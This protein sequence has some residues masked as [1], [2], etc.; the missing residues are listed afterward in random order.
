M[1]R[2][3]T[4]IRSAFAARLRE[5]GLRDHRLATL[6]RWVARLPDDR[7]A[8]AV[9]MITVGLDAPRRGRWAVL[10][11]IDNAFRRPSP[12]FPHESR[13]AFL[14]WVVKGRET[15]AKVAAKLEELKAA[16]SAKERDAILDSLDGEEA[17][18]GSLAN[19]HPILAHAWRA[20]PR[21]ARPN[22]GVHQGEPEPFIGARGAVRAAVFVA[23]R[24]A[25]LVPRGEKKTFAELVALAEQAADAGKPPP[26]LRAIV[27]R[28]SREGLVGIARAACAEAMRTLLHPDNAG[29]SARPAAVKA[30]N[31][32]L[33]SGGD[34][35]VRSFLAGLDAELRRLDVVHALTLRKK[36]PSRPI[37][38]TIHRGADKKGKPALWLARLEG[39]QLGLLAKQGRFW[40]WT[41]GGKEEILATVPDEHFENAVMAAK[42]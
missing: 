17:P 20:A 3:P 25:H 18:G 15:Q 1:T 28:T 12:A 41:E 14:R 34:D 33:E 4:A 38:S 29:T 36:E 37:T 2:G 9:E 19:A 31:L 22:G 13:L 5:E 7:V 10:W 8:E 11:V 16:R 21:S 6:Q 24:V 23:R 39:G 40:T 30:V 27:D 32:L 26:S 42:D 35:A